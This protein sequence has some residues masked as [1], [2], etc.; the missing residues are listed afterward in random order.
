VIHRFITIAWLALVLGCCA[1]AQTPEDAFN[2]GNEFYRAGKYRE[3]AKEYESIIRQGYVSAEVYFNLGNA[4]Y[5]MENLAQAILAY[6][7][8]ARLKPNDPDIQ[9]NLRLLNLKTIDR[10]EPVPEL[11]LIQWMRSVSSLASPETARG[12]FVVSW[13]ALFGSLAAMYFFVRREFLRALRIAL[14]VSLVFV[15]LSGAMLGLQAMRSKAPEQAV[16]T[17]QTIT[18]KSSPDEK[19]VD[20][21]VV[22][23]GLKVKL[24]DSVADW[25][26]ITLADGKVGWIPAGDCEKI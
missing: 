3:A 20:A 14:I 18:A 15:V 9:H 4:Y 1:F 19:S 25:V 13:I 6:E 2:R 23:E 11:F 17:A 16:I 5:R 22:H 21:F 26:K 12:F 10:I 24:T 7:R 8:A